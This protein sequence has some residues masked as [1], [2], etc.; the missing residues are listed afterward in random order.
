MDD[1][2]KP[3]FG[4]YFRRL[5]KTGRLNPKCEVCGDPPP[6]YKVGGWL[7]QDCATFSVT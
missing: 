7:C 1:D 4:T 5:L 2:S 3:T 6:L